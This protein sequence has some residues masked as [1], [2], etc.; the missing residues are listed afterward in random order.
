[1]GYRLSPPSPR[2]YDEARRAPLPDISQHFPSQSKGINRPT[3]LVTGDRR[4]HYDTLKSNTLKLTL[5]ASIPCQNLYQCL[6]GI[7]SARIWSVVNL[8]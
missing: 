1:M 8:P 7:Q 6:M 5:Y 4:V 2:D 3:V